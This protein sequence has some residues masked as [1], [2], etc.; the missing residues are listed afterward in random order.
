MM[1]MVICQLCSR[2]PFQVT[3]HKEILVG[4]AKDPS[5]KQA[6]SKYL[7]PAWSPRGALEGPDSSV[8]DLET[9]YQLPSRYSLSLIPPFALVYHIPWT[10]TFSRFRILWRHCQIQ[11]LNYFRLQV[12]G[13]LSRL[14]A[15]GRLPKYCHSEVT[16]LVSIAVGQ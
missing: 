4:I 8:A 14:K 7:S 13:V 16:Q 5:I 1:Q 6:I 10:Y 2:I 12:K 9:V 3:P 15:V 11:S